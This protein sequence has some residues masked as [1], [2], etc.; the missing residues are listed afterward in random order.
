LTS[1]SVT[2]AARA[3]VARRAGVATIAT[4]SAPVVVLAGGILAMSGTSTTAD[5]CGQG[6][7]DLNGI[8]RMTKISKPTKDLEIRVPADVQPNANGIV[9]PSNAGLSLTT[10]PAKSAIRFPGRWDS[11]KNVLSVPSGLTVSPDPKDPTHYFVGP[12]S[13]MQ[14]ETFRKSIGGINLGPPIMLGQ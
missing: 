2:L 9:V 10:D 11:Y 7:C 13:P 5:D 8:Y 6:R 4:V 12:Q 3:A 1:P 14:F